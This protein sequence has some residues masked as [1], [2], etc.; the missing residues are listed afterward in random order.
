MKLRLWA[1]AVVVE[2]PDDVVPELGNQEVAVD[3]RSAAFDAGDKAPDAA[4]ATD[5]T[6]SRLTSGLPNVWIPPLF[7]LRRSSLALFDG[8][9]VGPLTVAAREQGS[10]AFG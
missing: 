1:I 5:T 4:A 10:P 7:R 9:R 3:G 6:S 8:S 2:E